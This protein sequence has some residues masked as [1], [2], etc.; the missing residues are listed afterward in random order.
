MMFSTIRRSL[1]HKLMLL[2]LGTAVAALALSAVGLVFL[3]LR[4]YER[5]WSTDLQAQADIVARAAAPALH[6]NDRA[7]A[8]E[9]LGSL[10]ARPN[11][12]GGQLYDRAGRPFASY[13]RE[14][15]NVAFPPAGAD[16]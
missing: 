10:R 14:G 13:T 15:A 8:S 11:I 6:F 2:L 3:D 7:T 1:R 5:Q 9:D 4:A 16:V 12:V